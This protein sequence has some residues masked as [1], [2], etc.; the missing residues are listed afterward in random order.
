[1]R[2]AKVEVSALEITNTALAKAEAPVLLEGPRVARAW[3]ALEAVNESS[4]IG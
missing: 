1:M 2:P 4:E 3:H